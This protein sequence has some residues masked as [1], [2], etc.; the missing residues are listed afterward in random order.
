[1][2]LRVD[3]VCGSYPPDVCGVSD[4]SRRLVRELAVLGIDARVVTTSGLDASADADVRAEAVCPSWTVRGA[5]KLGRILR[6]R[7]ADVVHIQ[8]PSQRFHG[9]WGIH[10]LP[11]YLR[12]RDVRVVTTLHEYCMAPWGGRLKQLLNVAFSNRIILT[13]E[14]DMALVGRWT[15]P[16][17]LA[18]VRIGSNIEPEGSSDEG[19]ALLAKVGLGPDRPVLVFFGFARPGKGLETLFEALPYLPHELMAQ[20]A[21][22]SA[23]PEPDYK[24]R[25]SAFCA[26]LGVGESVKWTG[27]LPERDVSSVLMASTVA[28]LPFED[29]ASARRGSLLAALVHGVPVVT[30]AGPGTPGVFRH[31]TNM[32]LSPPGD[33]YE[34]AANIARMLRDDGLRADISHGAAALGVEFS[35]RQ[36]AMG[37]AEVYHSLT[38]RRRS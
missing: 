12:A 8:F 10:V 24:S 2:S 5:L 23:D 30:T 33:S 28:V 4:Y 26:E 9:Q 37:N 20:V 25:M 21:I 7:G 34:L 19:R 18:L 3:M 17:K 1:M 14:E 16:E 29:G 35:W 31:G 38:A 32:L 15:S 36:I 6:S 27:Y 22:V 13:N 11:I